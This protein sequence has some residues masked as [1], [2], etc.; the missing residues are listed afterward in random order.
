MF[1]TADLTLLACAYCAGTGVFPSRL[2]AIACANNLLFIRLMEGKGCR[3][4]TAERAS[5][6]FIENWPPNVP[7]PD[8]IPVPDGLTLVPPAPPLPKGRRCAT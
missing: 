4:S 8:S 1:S 3:A 6:W 5:R 2:G 7:W